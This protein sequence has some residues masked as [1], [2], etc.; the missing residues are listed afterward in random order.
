MRTALTWACLA[1]LIALALVLGLATGVDRDGNLDGYGSDLIVLLAFCALDITALCA[2]GII[3]HPSA[4][5]FV[6]SLIS[7]PTVLVYWLT[8]IANHPGEFTGNGPLGDIALTALVTAGFV[9]M[10][11]LL[12]G[13]VGA[14]ASAVVLGGRWLRHSVGSQHGAHLHHKR[15]MS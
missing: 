2:L 14:G 9:S 7:I 12:A 4:S 1:S 8:V 11:A 3:G 15:P 6:S 10:A 13:L 5:A